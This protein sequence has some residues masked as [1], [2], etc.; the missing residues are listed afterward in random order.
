MCKCP[1]LRT[2]LPGL[3]VFMFA[4][5]FSKMTVLLINIVE[6]NILVQAVKEAKRL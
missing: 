2:Y 1:M 3:R 6:A 5:A 4:H